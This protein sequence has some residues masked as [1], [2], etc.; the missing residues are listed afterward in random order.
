M[1]FEAIQELYEDNPYLEH[2]LHPLRHEVANITVLLADPSFSHQVTA[3]KRSLLAANG[4]L[5]ALLTDLSLLSKSER[6]SLDL[7]SSIEAELRMLQF[8]I[9]SLI[10][11]LNSNG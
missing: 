7:T 9:H 1:A 4:S 10:K 11:I 3:A 8:P 5:N 6:A 2:R